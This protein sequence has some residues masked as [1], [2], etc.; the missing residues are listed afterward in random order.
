MKW[1]Q[2]IISLSV[3][4]VRTVQIMPVLMG[5]V[6]RVKVNYDQVKA[7]ERM[8]RRGAIL[9]PP[10]SLDALVLFICQMSNNT[11]NYSVITQ[12]SVP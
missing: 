7:G 6:Y 8:M 1:E 12:Y 10:E 11:I 5:K 4:S 3:Y 9:F 2:Y